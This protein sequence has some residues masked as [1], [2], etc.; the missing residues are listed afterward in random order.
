MIDATHVSGAHT[1]PDISREVR[2]LC[3]LLLYAAYERLLL[4][5]CRSILETAR[6]LRCGNRRLK[7]GL[8]LFAAFSTIQ[9]VNNVSQKQIWKGK[10]LELVNTLGERKS[11]TISADVFP[12]DGSH[13]RQQQVVTFCELLELGE[14]GPILKNAWGRL[15][16]IVTQRNEI[17]HGAKTSEEIGRSYTVGELRDLV[18]IWELRWGEFIDHVETAASDRDFYRL[19][20]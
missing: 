8:R 13:M 15:N 7:P 2:G 18:D 12:T 20:K 6:S 19:P 3:V 11:C 14:P 9:S 10:G 17:A 4:S 1:S 16:T 5:L